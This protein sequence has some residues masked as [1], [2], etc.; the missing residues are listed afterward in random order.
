MA[1]SFGRAVKDTQA[2]GKIKDVKVTKE[3]ENRTHQQ[4]ADVQYL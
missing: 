3:V 4:F 2:E 1:E